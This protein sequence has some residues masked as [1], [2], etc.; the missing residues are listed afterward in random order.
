MFEAVFE[1]KSVT[2][3]MFGC[4]TQSPR[5]DDETYNDHEHRVW[6]EKVPLTDTGQA[7]INP[8]AVTNSLVEAAKWLKRKVPGERGA[9]FG[10][11]F[12]CG[13]S[14]GQKVLLFRKD[15][16]PVRIEDIDPLLLFV[17]SDGKHGGPKRVERIFPTL[18]EWTARGSLHVFDGKISEDQLMDHLVCVGQYVGWGAMRVANGGINGRFSV[19]S[20]EANELSAV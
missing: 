1:V 10:K 14:P 12:Q 4:P 13:V 3:L 2:D 18:H 16:K 8:F 6:R 11:R 7:Y 19:V 9:M 17:P 20:L 5:R 15:G